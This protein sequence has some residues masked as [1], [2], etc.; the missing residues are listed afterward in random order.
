MSRRMKRG[1]SVVL[2]IPFAVLTG[3]VWGLAAG[4]LSRGREPW[5]TSLMLS[6][7]AVTVVGLSFLCGVPHRITGYT[8]LGTGSFFLALRLVFGKR[9]ALEM[10]VGPHLF[11]I[12]L[13][14]MWPSIQRAHER[15]RGRV[16]YHQSMEQTEGSRLASLDG[17]WGCAQRKPCHD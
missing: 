9:A 1:A 12:L 14:L 10:F 3:L 17:N 13:L 7:L 6:G 2:L 16:G 11:A 4:R 8:F 15:H 5:F